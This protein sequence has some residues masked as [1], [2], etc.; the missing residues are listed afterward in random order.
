MWV[1]VLLPLLTQTVPILSSSDVVFACAGQNPCTVIEDRRP[2]EERKDRMLSVWIWS[3]DYGILNIGDGGIGDQRYGADRIKQL[4]VAMKNALK[5]DENH[6]ILI[7]K[8]AIFINGKA[9]QKSDSLKVAMGGGALVPAIASGKAKGEKCVAEKMKGGWYKPNEITNE[10]SPIVVEI[11]VELD[12]KLIE[13]RKVRSP[14]RQLIS[15]VSLTRI[16]DSDLNDF[17]SANDAAVNEIVARIS[18]N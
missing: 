18:Q 17:R 11:S 14:S 15:G 10:F 2:P 5:L 7:K 9:Y 6:T 4:A 13:V 1:A 16:T 8:Y 3:C 12:G